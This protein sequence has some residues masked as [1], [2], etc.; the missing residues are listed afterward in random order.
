MTG[1]ETSPESRAVLIGVHDFEHL[2]ALDGVRHNIPALRAR[3][4]DPLVGGL[5]E[6]HCYAVAADCRPADVLDAVQTAADEA[7]NLLLVYYAGHGLFDRDGHS[8]LLGT[9]TAHHASPHR[10]VKYAELRDYV[11]ES[12]ARHKV[13]IIDCCFSGAALPM[14]A[15]TQSPWTD[16]LGIEGASVLT[17]AADTEESLCLP[18]GSVFTLELT[19]LLGQGLKGPLPDGR[20]GEE[21]P[22]LTMGDVFLT[23]KAR[24]SGRRVGNRLV[25]QPRIANRDSGHLI[26]LA[27]NRSFTGV[28]VQAGPVSPAPSGPAAPDPLAAVVSQRDLV[29]GLDGFKKNLTPEQLPF[30][31]PGQDHPAAPH[32]LFSR[33]RNPDE[34]GILLVGSAGTGKT[35]TG[36]EVGR[37]ALQE[38]WRVLH[39][40]PGRESSITDRISSQVLAQDSPVL[41][42]IDYLNK[43]LKED[44]DNHDTPLD[45]T[46]LRH[47]LLPA[48]RRRNIQVALLASVR[49]G[50][51]HKADHTQ[52]RDV[53]D[54][55]ELRQDEEFQ[56]L[57]AD[58]ALARLAPTA[59]ERLGM[60]RMRAICG[61]RPIITLLVARELERRVIHD[62]PIPEAAGLRAS[63]ELSRWLRSRLEE[64]DLAVPGRK[65]TFD[66]VTASDS[67]V[68]AAAAAAACPQPH[69][70]VIAAANAALSR[71]PSAA[72]RADGVVETLIDLGWLERGGD[73]GD[74]LSTA[75]DVVCDQLVESV[76]LP[77]QRRAP[78]RDR[79][80]V[81]LSGCLV[82]P[83]TVG[84]Y[85]TH[86]GRV[87]NDLALVQRADAVSAVLDEWFVANA[88]AI[89][90]VMR[91]NADVGGYALGA[92]CS[93]PPWSGAAVQ[94]WQE[95]VGPWLDEFGDSVDARHVFYRGLGNL[96][97]DGA[98]LLLP[99]ALKWLESHGW[100][101]EASYV[102]GPLLGRTDVPPEQQKP[103]LRN[104]IGWLRRNG[105]LLEAHFVLRSLVART[106]LTAPQTR[107]VVAAALLWAERNTTTREVAPVLTALVARD[108]L[109]HDETRRT[110][111]A[112]LEWLGQHRAAPEPHK[113]LRTLLGRADLTE[114]ESHRA[115]SL[116]L[117]WLDDHGTVSSAT[118]VLR[119]LLTRTGID[120]SQADRAVGFA[121]RWLEHHATAPDADFLIHR[122]LSRTD[123]ADAKIRQTVGLAAE[124]LE[125]HAT[126]SDADFLIRQLLSRTDLDEAETRRAAGFAGRWLAKHATVPDASYVLETLLTRDDLSGEQAGEAISAA[127]VWL[128]HHGNGPA[129][130]YV[131]HALLT[132][133]DIPGPEA[134]RANEFATEWVMSRAD[135]FEA[136]FTLS[137]LLSRKDLTAE[138]ADEAVCAATTWLRHHGRTLMADFLLRALLPRPG[139]TGNQVRDATAFAMQWLDF[140]GTDRKSGL[141]LAAL[142]QRPDLTDSQARE[143]VASTLLWLTSYHNVPD[144]DAVLSALLDREDLSSDERRQ[145]LDFVAQR[146]NQYGAEGATQ[147]EA[148]ELLNRLNTRNPHGEQAQQDV[149]AALTWLEEHADLPETARILGAVFTHREL[150]EEQFRQAVAAALAW[151]ERH[152]TQPNA[153]YLLQ[154]LMLLGGLADDDLDLAAAH[155]L[156]WLE[157]HL[158]SGQV[159]FTLGSLISNRR[160]SAERLDRGISLAADWLERRIAAPHASFVLDKLLARREI[161][162]ERARAT[163]A[164]TDLWLR[165]HAP[166]RGARFVLT[167]L[168]ARTDLTAD[169]ARRAVS[170]TMQWLDVHGTTHEARYVLA[171]LNAQQQLG[172]D[173]IDRAIGATFSWLHRYGTPRDTRAVLPSLLKRTD[174]NAEQVRKLTAFTLRWVRSQPVAECWRVVSPLVARADLPPHQA[175]QVMSLVADGVQDDP[176]AYDVSFLLAAYLP[177]PDLTAEQRATA[178]SWSL[179]WLEHHMP[180]WRS[181]FVLEALLT[182]ADLTPAETRRVVSWALS[183]LDDHVGTAA[184]GFTETAGG[185]LAEALL[186][187]ADLDEDDLRRARAFL[188]RP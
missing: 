13:V 50:W 142:L 20:R 74:S 83:R 100:R 42:V 139:L 152:A 43:Y 58:Q 88:P 166:T 2:P 15:E 95:V 108:D 174:L 188:S 110:V 114:D 79:T 86:I 169:E 123:L 138:Q 145:A 6:R 175:C 22:L 64:D 45:L 153:S 122:L 127:M 60:D 177:R 37:I 186:G 132:R 140:Y 3:L 26:P 55:V 81:F 184:D 165:L 93:G 135:Q 28:P 62:L 57:V 170:R 105:T 187:R 36:L 125:H 99:A 130:G 124:W 91:R 39:V 168:L 133:T 112:T 23:L 163:V 107:Q 137:K 35:R 31:S 119:P 129:A 161:L 78:D 41:V 38:G 111:S 29:D 7:T 69:T 40:L 30:V 89:G 146:R 101:R 171:P 66:R 9:R 12:P 117:E 178:V 154:P 82:G 148:A 179:N 160:I 136:S 143:T 150:G 159:T 76:I 113:A 17:S 151:L 24:L 173:E 32:T 98:L 90:H 118:Y 75:H 77:E 155:A 120:K 54:E 63:G 167:P 115:V 61:H 27:R 149:T 103:A 126:T 84:R 156:Q 85:A 72:L 73:D 102:L 141:V 8:L 25:P 92:I 21:Q 164:F 5:A 70:E 144:A 68:V 131:L 48:A 65:N 181:C 172:A 96:P 34:R 157:H 94:N 87:V 19:D 46:A 176:T 128:R 185:T 71:T 109:H 183:W 53:F 158:D 52:L 104:A 47:R 134:R 182:S 1:Q 18:E 147:R 33:L 97:T 59:I 180:V 121:E 67:L 16:S 4:T 162:G 44:R 14:G 116:A 10:S 106:D 80:Y 56:R 51:L 11:A 49:P